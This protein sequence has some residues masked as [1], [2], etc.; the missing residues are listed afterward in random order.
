MKSYKILL[1]VIIMFIHVEAIAQ[2]SYFEGYIK[3][4]NGKPIANVNLVELN[5]NL[6]STK[7]NSAGHFKIPAKNKNRVF[8]I[9]CIGYTT[10]QVELS[11]ATGNTIYL[12]QKA[13]ELDG[14][15]IQG[16]GKTTKRLN[17]GNITRV[18]S[19]DIEAQ[20]I[21]NPLAALQGRVP[22]MVINQTSGVP[23]SSFKVEI[24]GR[25]SLDQ[26]LSKNDP[27]FVIDGVFFESGNQPTNLLRSSANDNFG[28]G[29][30]S[31]LN[32]INP[33]D[34]ES[35]EILKDADA[36]AIYGSRGAN[37]VILISTKKGTIGKT[38]LSINYYSGA[39]RVTRTMN[40]LNTK[41]YV[42]MRNEGFR[43]DGVTPSRNALD[44]GYA[45]DIMLWDTTR[46]TDFKE[47]LIGK[48]A[49]A[50]DIQTSLTGG[51]EFTN[52]LIGMGVHR[53][54]TVFSKDLSD[55]RI[56]T[57]FNI[58]H[59]TQDKKLSVML[60]GGYSND[61]NKLLGQDLTRYI[62]LPPNLLVYNNNGTLAWEEG[63][64]SYA[65]VNNVINPL[66]L[67]FR[68]NNSVNE[69]LYT[70]LQLE[71]K[72]LDDLVFKTSLS[73][74][75]FRSDE[76]SLTPR[77]AIDPYTYS[78][79]TP[80]SSFANSRTQNWSAE[81]Q[82]TY[83]NSFGEGKLNLLLGGS[84]Q[85]KNYRG[86]TINASQFSNDLLLNNP[87]AAGL[88]I[89]NIAQSE[90]KYQ[91]VFG[92]INY[93]L[94]EKYLL[95]FSFRRDG[96]SRF[97]LNRQFA[98][99][100]A[101]G[102]GWI[103]SEESFI[104]DHIRIL[105]FG[106]VRASLGLTGNDQIGDYNYMQ[107]WQNNGSG[108]TYQGTP[109]IKPSKVYNPDYQWETNR[110]FEVAIE[111][112]FFKNRIY[113]T[114]S[115]YNNKSD[116]QLVNY[117]LP[118]HTGFSNVVMNIPALVENS[119]FEFILD[120]KI[121]SGKNFSW[122]SAINLTL[123]KNKLI[124]YPGLES[125]SYK[126]V[127]VVG[128]P[129]SVLN[130]YKY[131][132]VNQA[133]GLYS[134]E[135]LNSDGSY[136]PADDYQVLGNLNPKFYGGLSNKLE[137]KNFQ[138]DILLEFKRQLGR[139]Y[140]S[141]TYNL[142]PGSIGNQPEIVLERWQ[143]YGDKTRIQK[144]TAGFNNEIKVITNTVLNSSNGIYSDASFIRLKNVSLSYKIPGVLVK[145]LGLQ[146]G[147]IFLNGQNILT[148]TKFKGLDPETQNFFVLPPLK[149]IALGAQLTF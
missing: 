98:N 82:I 104:K 67:L 81:P 19:K 59:I 7:T 114:V 125:T 126:N 89:S 56:S 87:A 77:A 10:Q 55:I 132:G 16:Y 84:W 12:E 79:I 107:L 93:N 94:K 86:L 33:S 41:Q 103:F 30:L 130:L 23:G 46:Y 61:N 106:K 101:L 83:N 115:Y 133:T 127:Y 72:I 5:N 22:G 39:S 68:T 1:S 134:F 51:N 128:N 135:D 85:A 116:N 119:G 109:T 97:G 90:Y 149:T 144:F 100:W 47:M 138:L 20:P 66:S 120:A 40:M 142:R 11:T 63:G 62:N 105:D 4:T 69:N 136:K 18:S 21:S 24:R 58:S 28:L 27:L 36:T 35:I 44:P 123:P 3:D 88:V 73:Y 48:T 143:Q 112:G 29:G 118:N 50:N 147:R 65:T 121:L 145:K 140:L 108:G 70:N 96:S 64:V 2:T 71:Y 141:E 80:S 34:I 60:S 49:Y 76:A 139:N 117:S 124:S 91:A 15:I 148:L 32:S 53:E 146:T 110:K 14:V 129:L 6:S 99:F 78:W 25:T 52:F 122:S 38:R 43:N 13:G 75:S 37:G 102:T 31:P 42:A 54:T 74:N 137:Y 9:S 8:R 113:T 131:L 111:L 45:P 95:N 57:H 92:R 17:T 26:S